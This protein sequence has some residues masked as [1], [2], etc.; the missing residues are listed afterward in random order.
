MQVIIVGAG[1]VGTD[2]AREQSKNHSVTVIDKDPDKVENINYTMDALGVEGDG[3]SI[4]VLK[5]AGIDQADILI[6]CTETDESNIVICGTARTQGDIFTIA[7][8]THRKYLDSWNESPGAFGVDYMVAADLLTAETIARIISTPAAHDV[9][10]FSEGSVEMAEFDVLDKSSIAGKTVQQADKYPSL[11]FAA[12]IKDGLVEIPTGETLIESGNSVIVIGDPETLH[13]FALEIA[14]DRLDQTE[15]I[16][17]LGGSEIALEIADI[18]QGMEFEPV[19][20]E[21]DEDRARKLAETLQNSLV[22]HNDATDLEFLKRES[23]GKSDVVV[24]ALDSDEKNLLSL[25]LID[26]LGDARKISVVTNTEYV[27]LFETVGIDVAVNPRE[28]VAEEIIRLTQESYTENLS[29][30]GGDQAEVIEIEVGEGS[31]LANRT[32]KEAH[33][34][35]STGVVIGAVSRDM[36]IIPARGDTEIHIGDHVILFVDAEVKPE[37]MDKV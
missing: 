20:V 31:V 14:P 34:D 33:K 32:I 7:R 18:L 17:I 11:T 35:L 24:S 25:L 19:I 1:Q 3:T 2:I 36:E 21:K 28:V 27:E 16:V 9:D 12:V 30:I 13:K 37:I 6:A 8:V 26:T 29:L 4:D 15:S 5:E 23:I 22:M 10:V